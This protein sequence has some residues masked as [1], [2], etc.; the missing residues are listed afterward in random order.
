MRIVVYLVALFCLISCTVPP[1]EQ[2]TPKPNQG[3]LD[4]W[5]NGA[6]P[7]LLDSE[8]KYRQQIKDAKKHENFIKKKSK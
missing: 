2:N 7:W 3:L 5:G 6:E 4:G 1:S 8:R